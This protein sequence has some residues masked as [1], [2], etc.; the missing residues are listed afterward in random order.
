MPL[1]NGYK[2]EMDCTAELKAEG[3]Q[4]YQEIVGQLRWAVELGRVDILLETSLMSSYLAMPR[5]G[6]L[7]QL[8]HIVGYLKSHK[9]MRILFDASHSKIKESWF[10]EYD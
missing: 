4:Q 6:H 5:E 2:P 1:S 9:K 10:Q 3:V 8:L 7:E